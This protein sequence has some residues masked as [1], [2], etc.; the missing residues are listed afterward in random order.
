MTA[1]ARLRELLQSWPKYPGCR[2][3]VRAPLV[4]PA[5]PGGFNLSSTEHHWLQEY[6]GFLAWDHDHVFTTIQSCVRLSDFERLTTGAGAR[7]LGVFEMA[8]L[9]GEIALR[10][11]P[12][13]RQLQTWQIGELVRLLT[14]LGI[15]PTRIHASYSAG[16]RVVDL[17]AGRYAFDGWIPPDVL[18]REAFLEAGVPE[19]NLV[20]DATRATLLALHVNRPTPWG[21]RNEI[22]VDV[23]AAGHPLLID[24]ATAEYF[25][26]RPRFRGETFLHQ[27]IIGLEPLETGATGIGCGLERLAM[28]AEGLPRI[29][30][31]DYLRPFYDALALAL[32]RRLEPGDYLAGESLRALH[33]IQGDLLAHPALAAA[34]DDG[35][36]ATVH[37]RRRKKLA[38][39]KRNVP[40][41]LD[42]GDLERLLLVHGRAQP[43]HEG[44]DQAVKPTVAGLLEY[45]HSSAGRLIARDGFE[46]SR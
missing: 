22:H 39:L 23:G 26:W 29:H 41:R 25:L 37:G 38:R 18:S 33:R 16:G 11:R 6:G 5:F 9:C 3:V 34:P 35:R 21:Y 8:D 2:P 42:A 44:L 46:S 15:P 28:V 36:V 12:D 4:T 19:A 30:D 24:V 17:T 32:G 45:R 14:G 40:P 43:W 20:P 1:Y 13:Y 7:Y 27:D 31:V 10:E